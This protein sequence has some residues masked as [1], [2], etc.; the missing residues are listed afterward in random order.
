VPMS[1]PTQT[2]QESA[3]IA[4]N[5]GYQYCVGYCGGRP[6]R[7]VEGAFHINFSKRGEKMLSLKKSRL[8]NAV[9]SLAIV[10]FCNLSFAGSTCIGKVQNLSINPSGWI[11]FS[12][13]D[14]GVNLPWQSLCNV[15]T[16]YNSIEPA[17]C[18]TMYTLLATA[19][20]LDKKVTFWF[21][22]AN[23]TPVS[24]DTTRFQ[25]WSVLVNGGNGWYF[26]P[27]FAN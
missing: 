13:V 25:P 3:C 8:C 7:W 6:W 14:G 16:T 20:A 5:F 22:I 2:N 24:C 12:L 17:V 9:A 27:A 11:V 21:D 15:S 18:K 19:S 23:P 10:A 26:G 4:R 1:M